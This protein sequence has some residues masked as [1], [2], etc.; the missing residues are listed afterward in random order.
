MTLRDSGHLILFR[1][2]GCSSKEYQSKKEFR[3]NDK[4]RWVLGITR[5]MIILLLPFLI[6]ALIFPNG[7]YGILG[8]GTLFPAWLIMIALVVLILFSISEEG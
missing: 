5:A 1:N 2:L 6:G 8:M 7:G 4:W 3:M